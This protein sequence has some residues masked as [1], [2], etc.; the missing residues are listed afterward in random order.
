MKNILFLL[1]AF[2]AQSAFAQLI[3]STAPKVG[4]EY[5]TARLELNRCQ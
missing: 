5:H 4:E 2:S 3:F 1:L